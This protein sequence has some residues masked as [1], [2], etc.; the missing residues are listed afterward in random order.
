M[1]KSAFLTALCAALCTAL[2]ACGGETAESGTT[3]IAVTTAPA[4][5]EDT[6]DLPDAATLSLAGDF[7]ILVSGNW[8]W[9]DYEAD[10]VDGT[11]VDN[12]IYRRN[13]Y[14]ADNYGVNITN[15]DIV[16]YSSAMG[17]GTGFTEL[18]TNY[19]SGD[20]VYDAAMVGTYDVANLA[21]QGVLQDLNDTPYI[22]LKKDYWD[23]RANADLSVG[24]RMYYTTGDISLSDN[25]STHALIFNKEMIKMYGMDDPYE[26]VRNN[27]WTLDKFA[28]MVKQVGDDLNNDGVYNKEDRMGLLSAVD[29]NLAILA[30][31]GEKI[32]TLNDKGEIELTLYSER[33]V[34]LYDDYLALIEDHTHVFNWQ[35]NYLDGTYGNVATTAELA[36]ML[37]SDRALFYFHMLFIMDE[38]RDLETDFGILPYP[39]YEATQADYGHLVSAWHAEFLCIP[40]NVNSLGRSGYVT[41]LL[42]YQGKKLLTPAYYEKTLVGQ[43]TRDEESAEM[44]D[45]IFATRTYD[46]GYYYALGT[47]KDLIGKMPINHMSLTTIYDTYRDT[48]ERKMNAINEMFSQTK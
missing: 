39:K 26:L 17:G 2:V 27:A 35:M 11:A 15:K 34:N 1:R 36:D 28:S 42:A 33:V 41:E 20:N 45:L 21:Y 30:A 8:A 18:Y 14:L 31:A 47:Y 48:A 10:G 16:A 22:N 19:M 37:N 29:N 38:L 23:Q 13:R 5:T 46:V 24:G 32:A 7:H 44:L 4:E 40:Q 6:P 43:Y 9:N 3:E 12:A 25:R